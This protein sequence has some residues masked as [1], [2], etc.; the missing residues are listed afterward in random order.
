MDVAEIVP[1]MVGYGLTSFEPGKIDRFQVK[2]LGVVKNGIRP[3]IDMI[4]ARLDHPN[5]PKVS[6]YF[7]DNDR[8]YLVMDF[9]EGESLSTRIKREGALPEAQV[10]EWTGQLLDALAYCHAQGVVHRDV[11]PHNVIIRS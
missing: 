6:D 1:G 4:L 8:D 5:L 3:G 7:S 2:I 9:V 10:L 11:K